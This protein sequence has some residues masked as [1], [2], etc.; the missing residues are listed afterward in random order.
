MITWDVVEN[1]A[2]KLRPRYDAVAE[3]A[4][5][6]IALFGAGTFGALCYDFLKEKKYNILCFMDNSKEKQGTDFC[7]FRVEIPHSL[8]K[9]VVLITNQTYANVIEQS[10]KSGGGGG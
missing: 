6:G 2:E 3:D 1:A 7:G 8:Q 5:D 9:G 4:G 10:W